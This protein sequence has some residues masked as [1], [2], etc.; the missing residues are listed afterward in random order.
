MI[1]L[2]GEKKKQKR[3]WFAFTYFKLTTLG[4]HKWVSILFD[5]FQFLSFPYPVAVRNHGL[6]PT[7]IVKLPMG[8]LW[9]GAQKL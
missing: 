1:K 4:M 8:H 7:V 6:S 2:D 9:A 5:R 3:Y